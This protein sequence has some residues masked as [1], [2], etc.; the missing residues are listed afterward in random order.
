[1]AKKKRETRKQNEG[2]V[3]DCSCENRR[4]QLG[5]STSGKNNDREPRHMDETASTREC[6]YDATSF[7]SLGKLGYTYDKRLEGRVQRRESKKQTEKPLARS[8]AKELDNPY[9]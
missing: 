4:G 8:S 1:V 9:S 2:V 6:R 3:I 5:D 7:A